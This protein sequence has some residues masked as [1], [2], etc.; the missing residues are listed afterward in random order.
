MIAEP[1]RTEST[2]QT[3][4]LGVKGLLTT[5]QT[6]I[7]TPGLSFTHTHTASVFQ[8]PISLLSVTEA[9]L[10]FVTFI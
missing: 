9:D 5:P 8:K 4:D 2:I 10:N 1:E 7:I 6:F 3:N